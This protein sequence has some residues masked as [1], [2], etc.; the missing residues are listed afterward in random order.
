M[1]FM[2]DALAELLIVYGDLG[3]DSGIVEIA[4][5]LCDNYL[6]LILKDKVSIQ[7]CL[8]IILSASK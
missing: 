6:K 3:N 2:V 4:R 8:K 5:Y 1:V 7:K